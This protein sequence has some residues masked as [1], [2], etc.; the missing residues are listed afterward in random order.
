MAKNVIYFAH[1]ITMLEKR[2]VPFRHISSIL[3]LSLSG[4]SIPITP[5][6]S[7]KPSVLTGTRFSSF[8][9]RTDVPADTFFA[10]ARC[11]KSGRNRFCIALPCCTNVG[12]LSCPFRLPRFWSELTTTLRGGHCSPVFGGFAGSFR[13]GR[14]ILFNYSEVQS[15]CAYKLI[16]N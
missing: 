2:P 14:R 11:R 3:S 4:L 1:K 12:N 6:I 8:Y 13:S 15:Q 10:A 5:T 16:V 7:R 9:R